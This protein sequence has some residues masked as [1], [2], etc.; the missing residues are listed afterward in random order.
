MHSATRITAVSPIRPGR[1]IAIDY[2]ERVRA[3]TAV[4]LMPTGGFRTAEGMADAI[5]SGAIDIIGLDG[6]LA[7]YG[8]TVGA[9]VVR[10]TLRRHH[11]PQCRRLLQCLRH[12]R[13]R[14]NRFYHRELLQH[15]HLRRANNIIDVIGDKDCPVAN[16]SCNRSGSANEHLASPSALI[17]GCGINRPATL[18]AIQGFTKKFGQL[19]RSTAN[20]PKPRLFHES[21]GG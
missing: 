11:R 12:D 21:R 5:D 13:C 15:S 18:Y 17:D 4:P 10:R 9:D 1:L 3:T 6:P 8:T 16:L 14:H 20:P 2:T 7:R 19:W